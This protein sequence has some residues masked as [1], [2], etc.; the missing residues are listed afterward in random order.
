MDSEHELILH[1]WP[2]RWDLPTFTPDCLAA[3]LYAQLTIPGE[4]VLEECTNPD[5]SPNG[6]LPYITHGL[7]CVASFPSIVK[8][9]AGRRKPGEP[10]EENEEE[11]SPDELTDPSA[12]L[13]SVERAQ[14]TAWIAFVSASLGDLV[15]CSFFTLRHNYYENVRPALAELFPVPQ[16]YYVPDRLREAYK[17]RLEAAGLWSVHAEEAEEEKRKKAS[18]AAEST[19]TEAFGREKVLDKARTTLGFLENLLK[20]K[21]FFFHDRPTTLDTLVAAHILL[22]T[23]PPLPNDLLRSLVAGSFPALHA[24]ARRIH[25]RALPT[26]AHPPAQTHVV[27]PLPSASLA[28]SFDFAEVEAHPTHSPAPLR[29]RATPTASFAQLASSLIPPVPRL[30]VRAKN[31]PVPKAKEDKEFARMRWAWY[32]LSLLGV[33]AWAWA[34]GLRIVVSR[35]GEPDEDDEFLGGEEDEVEGNEEE[36]EEP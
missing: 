30:L 16:R 36:E 10:E 13:S 2:A 12:S 22:L 25:A 23:F 3:V 1:V 4:F 29:V 24:H 26:S 20:D 15:A 28:P 35:S 33:V 32:G 21:P 6:Q 5:L 9:I 7:A 11:R 31:T 19:V 8:Y 27:A 18:V 34:A 14:Q 17:P